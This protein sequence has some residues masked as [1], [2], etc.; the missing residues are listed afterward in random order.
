MPLINCPQ[1]RNELS[2][3]A[4]K[5]P[6]CGAINQAPA[7][8]RECPDC[9]TKVTEKAAICPQ[10]GNPN[11]PLVCPECRQVAVWTKATC[12]ECGYDPRLANAGPVPVA[13]ADNT[14]TVIKWVA[15]G[16]GALGLL[17]FLAIVVIAVFV[18]LGPQIKNMFS[19]SVNAQQLNNNRAALSAT[20]YR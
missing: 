16:I 13:G 12:P 2:T 7:V 20:I 9:H 18:A 14:S 5:C 11:L 10:C 17:P 6:H 3:S 15:I 1:C 8:E 4:V 19:N